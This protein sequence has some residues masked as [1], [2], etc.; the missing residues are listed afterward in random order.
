MNKGLLIVGLG[1]GLL[2]LGLRNQAAQTALVD[3][4]E[5]TVDAV[6]NLYKEYT[7]AGIR[8]NNP[9]NVEYSPTIA[10]KGQIGREGV[11]LVFDTAENGIRAMARDLKTK[12]GSGYNTITKIINRY[13]PPEDNG[14][15]AGVAA[16]VADVA[17]RAGIS[18]T[19]TV[20][21]AHIAALVPAMIHH[22]NGVMPYPPETLRAGIA[23][24]LA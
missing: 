5:N 7:Q 21:T 22:E 6:S 10:W 18:A 4:T 9:G 24:A 17:T 3:L 16:Y 12:I 8:R 14:G 13:A 20:T 2:W 23:A 11:Y 19:A 1:A 15:A